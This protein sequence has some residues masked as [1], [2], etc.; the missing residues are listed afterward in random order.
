MPK[1][2]KELGP[3]E[4][5]RLKGKGTYAVGGVAGLALQ[6]GQFDSRSWV[7]RYRFRGRRREAGLG[8]Y[9][10]VPLAKAREYAREAREQLREGVDPI[11][12]R[13]AFRRKLLTF[14]EAV[15]LYD[16]EKAVEFRSE[17]HRRQWRASLER[18]AVPVIGDIAVSDVALQDVLDVLRPIW[19]S[20]TET[21]SKVRQRVERVLDYATVSGYRTGEN[22]ARW[23]GNLDM[24]LP[25]ATK[26]T[27]GRNYPA[28]TLDDAAS[29]FGALA[30]RAGTSARALE[31]QALTAART[32]A[33]RF[34]TW[35]E[36]DL[37]RQLWTIQPGRASSKIPPSVRPHRVPLS[38]RAMALLQEL[39][40]LADV[41]LV[42][43][44][45]KGWA[46]SDAALSAV[47]RKM[48]EA[49]AKKGGSGFVDARLGTPAVPHG[50]RSTFRTLVGERTQYDCDMAE[51]A[52]AHSVGSKV[53]QAYD[54][55]DQVEKRRCMMEDW[56][57]FLEGGASIRDASAAPGG[58]VTT[59]MTET[60]V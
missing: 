21:A 43:W 57:S 56:C 29:W 14:C 12:H 8:P 23:R 41:S 15:A 38:S 24:I 49:S 28:L 6:I 52:L 18:H 47:M 54:R 34:M 45:R 1:R 48:H 19:T 26:L 20:K 32:G 25:A 17:V 4:V 9:P 40:R 5:K 30:P 11:A 46:L 7:F 36:I 51:I 42:F 31:F 60:E 16:N 35:E 2:A 33:V 50:L 3:L 27:G 44:N 22:P 13:Q 53:R 59:G 37:D 55:A 39:P 10:D 58:R